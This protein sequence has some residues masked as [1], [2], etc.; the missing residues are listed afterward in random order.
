MATI[1]VL[2]PLVYEID[3]LRSEGLLALAEEFAEQAIREK[4]SVL[5]AIPKM[6]IYSRC[7]SKRNYRVGPRPKISIPSRKLK[8]CVHR[9]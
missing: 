2:E 3:E 5:N 6:S 9:S 8:S 7:R 4:L 1:F